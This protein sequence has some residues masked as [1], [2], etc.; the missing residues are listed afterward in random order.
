[1]LYPV[2]G[3][4]SGVGVFSGDL[5]RRISDKLFHRPAISVWGVSSG[6]RVKGLGISSVEVNLRKFQVGSLPCVSIS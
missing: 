3:S 6:F 5:G 4:G 1:M 2:S